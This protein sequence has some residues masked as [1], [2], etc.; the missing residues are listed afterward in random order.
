M[1]EEMAPSRPE[2]A[3]CVGATKRSHVVTGEA[4]GEAGPFAQCCRD[5]IVVVGFIFQ[6]VAHCH[7]ALG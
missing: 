2:E 5:P 1:G 4:E 6:K 7:R 3:G